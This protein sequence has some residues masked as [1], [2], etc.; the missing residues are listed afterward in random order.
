M[1]HS[2]LSISHRSNEDSTRSRI[3]VKAPSSLASTETILATSSD[4]SCTKSVRAAVAMLVKRKARVPPHEHAL[5]VSV[6][7]AQNT[8]SAQVNKSGWFPIGT[9][10]SL[11]SPSACS[12]LKD[13]RASC[14]PAAENLMPTRKSHSLAM[15]AV[16]K[17]ALNRARKRRE[18]A[19]E[20]DIS[21]VLSRSSDEH[22]STISCITGW[23]ESLDG[24]RLRTGSTGGRILT[25]QQQTSMATLD[26]P[27]DF[28]INVLQTKNSLLQTINT[29]LEEEKSL[30]Q[31]QLEILLGHPAMALS[32][33]TFDPNHSHWVTLTPQP[34]GLNNTHVKNIENLSHGET[35][36]TVSEDASSDDLDTSYEADKIDNIGCRSKQCNVASD[37]ASSNIENAK[38]LDM[39]LEHSLVSD[40]QTFDEEHSEVAGSSVNQIVEASPQTAPN[41]TR[42]HEPQRRQHHEMTNMSTISP[43]V[44]RGPLSNRRIA[45]FRK[46]GHQLRARQEVMRQQAPPR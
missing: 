12:Q 8:T 14:V 22:D 39:E 27:D 26:Q 29:Q 35:C 13:T 19:Q 18:R 7:V 15:D 41:T 23:E 16:K 24:S 33:A 1:Q 38:I 34:Y 46:A 10:A 4:K 21:A 2:P 11:P 30:L 42:H 40:E 31:Q 32:T 44:G 6:T 3:G 9:S 37:G 43:N 17:I 36:S 28:A 25:V 5:V 20:Q 45:R